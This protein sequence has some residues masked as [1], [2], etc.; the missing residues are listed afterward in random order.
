M[1][2]FTADTPAC[3]HKAYTTASSLSFDTLIELV[4]QISYQLEPVSTNSVP[5]QTVRSTHSA[6]RDTSCANV[7]SLTI[8]QH[9]LCLGAYISCGAML[10]MC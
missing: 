9:Q 4:L 6:E 7:C 1:V 3:H 2:R 10:S 5:L 8:S